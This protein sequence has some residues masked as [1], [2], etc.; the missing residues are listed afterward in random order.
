MTTPPRILVAGIGNIFLGD[1]AFG[2]EVARRL[3]AL[4]HPPNV[5]VVD[6]G[7]RGLDLTYALLDG[8]DAAILIDAVPR[9]AAPP[10][11]LYVLEPQ[12]DRSSDAPLPTNSAI[13]AHSM[14]PFRVLQTVAAMGGRCGRV[15]M[16]GCEPTAPDPAAPPDDMPM[17]MTPPV[18]AA[19]DE[20]VRLVESLIERLTT[21][22][23]DAFP[24]ESTLPP[25]EPPAAQQ[26]T[27]PW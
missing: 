5:R 7:I 23:D 19:I 12:I 21:R 3:R 27:R 16:V 15:L 9:R 24:I 25:A 18:R 22:G 10:G 20:A 11:T 1:D 14:D 8:C 4:P 13:D 2:S 17:D 26:E 6:F